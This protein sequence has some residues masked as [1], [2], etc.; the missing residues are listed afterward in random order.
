MRSAAIGRGKRF[1][2]MNARG[3]KPAIIEKR[4]LINSGHL[5]VYKAAACAVSTPLIGG[6]VAEWLK[7]AV[8]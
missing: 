1:F 5:T 7:A 2:E 8:C 4:G 3:F 6:G